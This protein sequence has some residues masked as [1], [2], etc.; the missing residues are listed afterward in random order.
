MVVMVVVVFARHEVVR[1]VLQAGLGVD[2]LHYIDVLQST[3]SVVSRANDPRDVSTLCCIAHVMRKSADPVGSLSP[4]RP[5]SVVRESSS[6]RQSLRPCN[7]VRMLSGHGVLCLHPVCAGSG[8][9]WM[10]VEDP[11]VCSVV[12]STQTMMKLVRL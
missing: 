12:S 1:H 7:S 5:I 8:Y 10:V 9:E 2:D 11:A 4:R 6:P 3:R